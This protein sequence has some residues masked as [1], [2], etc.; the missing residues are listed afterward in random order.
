VYGAILWRNFEE[1][2]TAMSVSSAVT[3]TLAR[4]A[5]RR[6]KTCIRFL[7]NEWT[8]KARS[9]LAQ[10][11]LNA[12]ERALVGYKNVSAKRTD[13]EGNRHTV[14]VNFP[15]SKTLSTLKFGWSLCCDV[16]ESRACSE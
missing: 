3:V 4:G 7:V 6:V 13:L 1:I 10:E 5:D 14:L 2:V 16:V 8:A 9:Q 11:D 12:N 15:R